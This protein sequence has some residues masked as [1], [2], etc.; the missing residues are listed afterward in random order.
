MA[1]PVYSTRFIGT[2]GTEAATVS[3]VVPDG[4]VAIVRD[5]DSLIGGAGIT[6]QVE[7][8]SELP[9]LRSAGMAGADTFAQWRGRQIL[10]A[11]EAVELQVTSTAAAFWAVAVS[12]YLLTV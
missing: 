11:G 8:F 2:S 10:V 9:L 4:F 3:L 1:A 5:I 12:G 7:I 6:A